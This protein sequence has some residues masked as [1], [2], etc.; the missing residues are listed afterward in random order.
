[1]VFNGEVFN[2]ETLGR[3]L[4][5]RTTGDV[6]VLMKLFDRQGTACLNSLNGFFAFAFYNRQADVMHIVRDRLGI[7]PLYY[8][9]DEDLLVF[10]SEIRP[11]LQVVGRQK[12]NREAIYQYFRFNYMVSPESV[13]AN[14]RQLSVGHY[15]EVKQNKATLRQW[16]DPVPDTPGHGAASSAATLQELLTDAVKL[17]LHAD[18]PV[19]CFLSGGVDSSVVSAIAARH[20][21]QLHTFSIGF[22]D[23]PFFDETAYAER[24]ATH[25]GSQHHTFRLGN[26]DLFENLFGFLN[27]MD[28]PFADSSA[29]NVYILSK[30]T[31]QHVKV[32]LSG[33]GADELFMGYNKH[34]AEWLVRHSVYRQLKPVAGPLLRLLPKS[35]QGYFSNKFRQLDR[36]YASAGM[37]AGQRYL[38]WAS[39]STPQ[40][41][42]HLLAYSVQPGP[43]P[44][45]QFF[46]KHEHYKALNLA[47][48]DMVLGDDMLV[49]VDRMSMRQGLE[50]RN[51][52]LDYRVVEFA[53]DLPVH[54]KISRH[55]Q[56]IILRRAFSELLPLEIFSR[57]KKGFEVPLL[58][59]F[60]KELRST[61]DDIWLSKTFIEQQGLFNYSYI[62]AL[63]QQLGAASP[64]DV[65]AKV[66]AL[67][68]FQQWF[69]NHQDHIDA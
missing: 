69:I 7:K 55:E 51:P 67:I 35:R 36:F 38:S 59:W 37:P 13:F 58:K 50:V 48:L 4:D 61:I 22:R 28:E 17:R 60:N 42:D 46:S 12:L 29:L 16:Y 1:M 34:R 49:K 25:I 6:E 15:I 52:F 47:D 23:E 65:A 66:W 31:R 5:C 43:L 11:L 41:L 2:Y 18:V 30:L 24:V 64:G 53:L 45:E 39:I 20:H 26:N 14:I 40:E 33:D 10:A 27:S 62:Q 3:E 56:K 54:E 57:P 9:L 8:Y 68:V 21:N 32:A 63:R 44:V 19:G